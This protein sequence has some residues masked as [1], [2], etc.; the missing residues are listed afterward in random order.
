MSTFVLYEISAVC[1]KPPALSRSSR[2]TRAPTA[3]RT[4]AA[5]PDG[6]LCL[7]RREWSAAKCRTPE[8]GNKPLDV[9][10]LSCQCCAAR[11]PWAGWLPR[12]RSV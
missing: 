12:W 3:E 5:R 11:E 6:D 9:R 8:G 10:W 1:P 7:R 2:S 4:G